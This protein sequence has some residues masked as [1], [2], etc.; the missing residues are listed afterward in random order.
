MI[1]A[2]CLLNDIHRGQKLGIREYVQELGV[3]YTIIDVGWWMQ[4]NLPVPPSPDLPQ[5]AAMVNI[6]YGTG[7]HKYLL[8]DLRHVGAWVARIVADP[9][10]LNQAV[11]VWED[12]VDINV[13]HEIGERESG[14]GDALKAKRIYVSALLLRT[15]S[16]RQRKLTNECHV[17]VRRG[18]EEA[19]R[20][21]RS[22]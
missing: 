8:T 16:F 15:L 21:S 17:G 20:R 5:L 4:F 3:P 10:T 13:A 6:L 7:E 2:G 19:A 18:G 9:R 14:D 12:E 11:I 1:E 22:T